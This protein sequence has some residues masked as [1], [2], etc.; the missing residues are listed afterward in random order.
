MGAKRS[1]RLFAA[2]TALAAWQLAAMAVGN[3]LLLASPIRVLGRLWEL[4]GEPGFLRTV[5]FSLLRIAAGFFCGFAVSAVLAAIAGRFPAAEV[6]LHPYFAAIKTVPVASVIILCLVWMSVEML[7]A[8]VA[9]LMVLPILYANLLQGIRAAD[10]ELTE[11]ARCYHIP[12]LR[13]LGYIYL[14]SVK[15][16]L[17]SGCSS[18]LGLS[19]KAGVAAE[20]IG[21]AGGSVGERLYQAKIYM[22]TAELFAWTVVIVA[23]SVFF[24]KTVLWVI[25]LAFSGWERR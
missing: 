13:R 14:P 8:F 15:P 11:M 21:M 22:Q 3:G 7:S 5:L 10:R 6:F 1:A 12:P 17:L 23:V 16:Y 9:F 24:E 18:A 2:L 20:V 25:R 19:W 4:L